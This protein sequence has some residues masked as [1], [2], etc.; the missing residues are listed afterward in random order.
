MKF[1]Y[2]TNFILP[3]QSQRSRFVFQDGSRSLGLFW[4]EKNPSYNRRN[5]VSH[6]NK[7]MTQH[8]HWYRVVP[9]SVLKT[10]GYII[11][12]SRICL[13]SDNSEIKSSQSNNT[14]NKVIYSFHFFFEITC[15]NFIALSDGKKSLSILYIMNSNDA[16]ICSCH[17]A[18]K[19]QCKLNECDIEDLTPVVISY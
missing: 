5:T 15:N 8:Q 9:P 14:Q 3:K 10:T 11:T 17:R 16:F 2:N 12:N 18:V 13:T 7:Y 19:M 4:K 1:C 6:T